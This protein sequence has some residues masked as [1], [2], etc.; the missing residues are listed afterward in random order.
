[1]REV[2][3]TV[4]RPGVVAS[5]PGTSFL[6]P[7]VMPPSFSTVVSAP[8]P[9]RRPLSTPK[10][11]PAREQRTSSARR[12]SMD[13]NFDDDSDAL[14]F[15]QPAG[16]NGF[17]QTSARPLSRESQ[18]SSRPGSRGPPIGSRPVRAPK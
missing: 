12:P 15:A 14:E 4:L 5:I 18:P 3:L 2:D 11:A 8:Q 17:G 7:R 6:D 1:V 16:A 13:V 10:P 9:V